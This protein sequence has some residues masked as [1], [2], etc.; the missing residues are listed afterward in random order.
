MRDVL[1]KIGPFSIHSYGLF[2][3]IGVLFAFTVGMYR[4]KRKGLDPEF[5]FDVGFYSGIVGIICTRLLYYITEIPAIIKDPSILW[6]FQ[7]GY[8]VYGGI[9]GGVFMGFIYCK[10]K[11]KKFLDYLD[12]V[13]PSIILAQAFGRIGCF[14][15]GC[16]YGKETQSAFSIV[17]HNSEM[18]PNE[19]KLIPTQLMSSAGDFLIFFILIFYAKRSKK[20]GQVGAMYLI[21]Y[22]IGRF[23]IE[24]LRDDYR[25]SIGFLSTSQA[26]SIL[27]VLIGGVLF[28]IAK[29][30]TEEKREQVLTESSEEESKEEK[31]DS[32]DEGVDE[33]D[34]VEVVVLHQE[35]EEK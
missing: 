17:Y 7:Y 14:M 18:A 4:A 19:V 30:K 15:T 1:L 8:V 32:L 3:A 25:G 5:V 11:N 34:E 26:I 16:C 6:D 29:P 9:I 33:E 20:S 10:K 21:L 13:M 31:A 27:I 2:I 12:I 22:S 35:M 28:A 24:F 23:F